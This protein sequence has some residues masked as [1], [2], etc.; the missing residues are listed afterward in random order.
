MCCKVSLASRGIVASIHAQYDIQ[1]ECAPDAA[2]SSLYSRILFDGKMAE[3]F[4]EVESFLV[5]S[6]RVG[7][8]ARYFGVTPL[9]KRQIG[10]GGRQV[11]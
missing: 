3:R 1:P 11:V 10:A 5:G 2:K 7:C 9:C 6:S 8:E 4:L